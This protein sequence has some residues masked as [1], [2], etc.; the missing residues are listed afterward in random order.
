MRTGRCSPSTI[1][2][3]ARRGRRTAASRCRQP[4]SRSL[5]RVSG[6][7]RR[8]RGCGGCAACVGAGWRGGANGRAHPR[9]Q[10]HGERVHRHGRASRGAD[11]RRR[12]RRAG[13]RGERGHRITR[14]GA[15]HRPLRAPVQGSGRTGADLPARPG[16]LPA[17][18]IG[19]GG[20]GKARL[21][22]QAAAEASD[23]FPGGVF[24]APLAALRDS[25]PVLAEVA[26]AVGV[27]EGEAGSA[28]DDLATSLPGKKML[29]FLDNLEHLL[30]DG[31]RGRHL[32]RAPRAAR[33]AGVRGAAD[34]RPRPALAAAS[35]ARR[36]TP[37][38]TSTTAARARRAALDL[39]SVS[40]CRP[41][42]E[43]GAAR[44]GAR[45]RYRAAS[46]SRLARRFD[47]PDA[48]S[49]VR[50]A[51]RAGRRPTVT[52]SV[53]SST[54]GIRPGRTARGAR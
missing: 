23:E 49:R 8:A 19:P 50:H 29:V 44:P 13:A 20:T 22:L 17:S 52:R 27:R 45:R 32:A 4:G 54:P 3:A 1:A 5:R 36:A 6:A 30:P 47:R 21:A 16:R 24:W 18:L 31:D 34:E 43:L 14:R 42:L 7:V 9:G 39:G 51:P 38:S 40:R 33:R 46:S 10:G 15:A 53:P 11:R 28:L 2:Y 26:S 41:A 35:S 37:G 12:A 25:N 48:R